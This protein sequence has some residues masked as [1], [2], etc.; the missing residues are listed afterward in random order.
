VLSPALFARALVLVAASRL[1][2]RRHTTTDSLR[3]LARGN[4][5]ARRLDPLDALTAVRRAARIAGGACLA[6]AVALTALLQR[7][8]HEP[9]L[10]L[11]SHRDAKREWSAHAWVEVDQL[12]LEPVITVEHASLAKL[13]AANGWTPSPPM[14]SDKAD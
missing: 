7:A 1:L 8:G 14:Q 13:K 4:G 2:L 10:V 9:T 12:L 5:S 3:R 6:Q 11:G